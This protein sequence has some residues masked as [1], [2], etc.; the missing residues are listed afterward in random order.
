ML[1]LPRP[2]SLRRAKNDENIVAL[3]FNMK[4]YPA[5]RIPGSGTSKHFPG[6][7]LA[8]LPHCIKLILIRRTE[9]E[10]KITFEASEIQDVQNLAGRIAPLVYPNAVSIELKSHFPKQRRW[11]E[12][13]LLD[14][15]GKDI[16]VKVE[17]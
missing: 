10:D 8:F 17:S 1:Y 3:G 12:K 4:G 7:V 16:V 6:D 9:T 13:M 2:S 14:W 11:I 5:L 15:D